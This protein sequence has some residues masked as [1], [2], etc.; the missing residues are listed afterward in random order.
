MSNI[1]YFEDFDDWLDKKDEPE[2]QVVETILL[3][4]NLLNVDYLPKIKLDFNSD[5]KH[6]YYLE[7]FT[8]F[9]HL[10]LYKYGWIF[11]Y[12]T[13][14]QWAGLCSIEETNIRASKKNRNLYVSIDYVKHDNNWEKNAKDII[15]HEIA[16]AIIFEV[17]YF[18]NNGVDLES[19]DKYH[20]ITNGHGE[21]WS[22]ICKTIS[23]GKN[24]DIFYKDANL[25]ESFKQYKYE[26]FN[27]GNVEYGNFI[28][29]ASKCSKCFK[30]II[31][32][33]NY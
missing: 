1:I 15:L 21:L 30:H 12:G 29:F 13:S 28:N 19:I 25:K 24:C 7:Y 31:I 10:N 2:K 3:A 22:L 20:T 9:K 6:K 8:Q 18:K 4:N 23:D 32:E 26:C 17:F 5:E 27:C 33:K 11:Q 14:K 16:H